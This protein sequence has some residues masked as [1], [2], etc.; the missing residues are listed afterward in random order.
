IAFIHSMQSKTNT[1]GPGCVFMNTGTIF[2]GVPSA[3]AWIGY[4]LGSE[5][6]NLPAYVAIPDIR[7]E[8]PNGKANWSNG[9][10]P[11]QY[12]AVVMAAQQPVRNVGVPAGVTPSEDRAT[13]DYLQLLNERHADR[14][15]G[16]SE[17]QARINA[18]TLAARMQ[19]SAPQTLDFAS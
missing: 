10:L 4:A 1:H 18:Y 17:L 11:A 12:Q 9:F 13:R 14:N 6:E 2:E 15:P 8:P 16:L 5:N 3:G 7:G 19:L